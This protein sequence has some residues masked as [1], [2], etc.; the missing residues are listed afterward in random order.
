MRCVRW[1][2]FISCMFRKVRSELAA[3]I[4]QNRDALDG[5]PALTLFQALRILELS[6]THTFARCPTTDFPSWAVSSAG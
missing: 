6:R 3:F 4:T 1:P 2:G 5:I